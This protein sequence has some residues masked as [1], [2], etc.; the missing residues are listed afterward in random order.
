MFEFYEERSSKNLT[1]WVNHLHRFGVEHF[2]SKYHQVSYVE[3]NDLDIIAML[4]GP[5]LGV[6]LLSVI[7]CSFVCRKKS[8]K[9]VKGD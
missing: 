6:L 3:L 9:K 1:Y 7:V 5:P 2:R 8:Q 4:A